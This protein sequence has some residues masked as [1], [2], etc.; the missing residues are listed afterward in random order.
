[1]LRRLFGD[2]ET[3]SDKFGRVCRAQRM[4][5][6]V[7][8]RNIRPRREFARFN[9]AKPFADRETVNHQ[10]DSDEERKHARN[11]DATENLSDMFWNDAA[12]D[13]AL[14]EDIKKDHQPDTRKTGDDAAFDFVG[15]LHLRRDALLALHLCFASFTLILGDEHLGHPRLAPIELLFLLARLARIHHLTHGI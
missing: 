7:A 3:G 15:T 6:H 12:F 13:D 4:S 5:F 1:M 9:V 2:T 11:P 8:F 10:S 14:H